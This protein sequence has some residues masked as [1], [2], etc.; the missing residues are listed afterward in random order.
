LLEAHKH[1]IKSCLEISEAAD[2]AGD[3]GTNDLV[4][5]DVLRPNELQS[6]FLTEHLVEMPLV[7]D[8]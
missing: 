5:S 3:Q 8:K 7:L 6:W 2:E 1:I 4:V